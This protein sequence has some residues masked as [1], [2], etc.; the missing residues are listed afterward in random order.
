MYVSISEKPAW[1]LQVAIDDR[2]MNEIEKIS[3]A[4]NKN[5]F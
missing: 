2:R 1:Y 5:F 4:E 3:L